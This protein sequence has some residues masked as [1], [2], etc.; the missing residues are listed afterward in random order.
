MKV[1]VGRFTPLRL[2]AVAEL[3]EELLVSVNCQVTAPAAVGSNCTV[4]TIAWPGLSVTGK[5]EPD[6][7]K[8]VPVTVPLL[9]VTAP[10][11]EDVNV[12]DFVTAVF[13]AT[14]PK[15]NVV[16][17]AVTVGMDAFNCKAKPWE[18]PPALAVT[19]TD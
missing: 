18:V 16:A 15:V 9:I 12:T 10:V 1:F 4:R 8:P 7:E 14:L 19:I 2:T 5:V 3:D 11:P 17:L 13:T 6:T